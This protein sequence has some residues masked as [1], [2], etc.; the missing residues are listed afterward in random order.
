MRMAR[1]ASRSEVEVEEEE[2]RFLV[3][4]L[5]AEVVEERQRTSAK[6]VRRWM[7]WR[8][9]MGK[10]DRVLHSFNA[11]MFGFHCTCFAATS[12]SVFFYL[13]LSFSF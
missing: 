9:L 3:A 2:R 8:K 11:S 1:I 10:E 5:A 4:A 13:L 6:E 7:R 12:A